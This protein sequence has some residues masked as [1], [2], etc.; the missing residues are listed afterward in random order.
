M[1]ICP[2]R[3]QDKWGSG[4]YMASRG[5]RKHNG[6]DLAC[7]KGSTILADQDGVVTKVGYPYPPEHAKKGHFRYVEVRSDTGIRIRYFYVAPSVSVGQRVMSGDPIGKTQGLI[8][9]YP[10]ITDHYHFEVKD[11]KDNFINPQEYLEAI[12]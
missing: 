11:S 7:Y 6:I 5:G 3:G 10:G 12:S 1:I 9:V 2:I 8:S 4:A